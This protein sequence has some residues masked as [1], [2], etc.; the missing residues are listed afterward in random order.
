MQHPTSTLLSQKYS[1]VHQRP[2]KP[3]SKGKVTESYLG[4]GTRYRP[5]SGSKT[6]GS[7]SRV[8]FS[9]NHNAGGGDKENEGLVGGGGNSPSPSK[10]GKRPFRFNFDNPG[11]F[12]SWTKTYTTPAPISNNCYFC[13]DPPSTDAP[14]DYYFR[15]SHETAG[16]ICNAGT[17][18]DNGTWMNVKDRTGII[19]SAIVWL[20]MLYS[21]RECEVKLNGRDCVCLFLFLF[22][23]LTKKKGFRLDAF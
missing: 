9:P 13:C 1:S 18:S 14:E 19:M 17:D 11:E 20:L 12:A 7:S 6:T 3:G 22:L 16:G 21:T 2:L 5:N 23:Y 10:K 8:D 4:G 15:P